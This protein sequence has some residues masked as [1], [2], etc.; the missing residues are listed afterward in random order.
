MFCYS[1]TTLQ[2][3]YLPPGPIGRKEPINMHQCW[4]KTSPLCFT[5]LLRD[6]QKRSLCQLL[7]EHL[8]HHNGGAGAKLGCDLG[9][10]CIACSLPEPRGSLGFCNELYIVPVINPPINI[11]MTLSSEAKYSFVNKINV[12]QSSQLASSPN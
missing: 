4:S 12:I 7:F 3:K 6:V 10:L 2:I 1:F 11:S 9:G 5:S 8:R